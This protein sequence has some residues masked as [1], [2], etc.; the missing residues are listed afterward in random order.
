[1]RNFKPLA[2]FCGCTGWFES[3]VVENPEDRFYRDVAQL[4][5]THM[6]YEIREKCSVLRRHLSVAESSFDI[7]WKLFLLAKASATGFCILNM[8]RFF[9]HLE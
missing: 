2:S 1:M 3:H 4:F 9:W 5:A 7:I 8:I 6:F